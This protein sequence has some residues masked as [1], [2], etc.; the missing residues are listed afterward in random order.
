MWRRDIRIQKRGGMIDGKD[1]EVCIIRRGRSIR[2][3]LLVTII[4]N[5]KG[6]FSRGL[7][8]GEG[9]VIMVLVWKVLNRRLFY[10]DAKVLK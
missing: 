7:E 1:R 6:G 2:I 9:D 4:R 3:E 8:T 5:M 10:V